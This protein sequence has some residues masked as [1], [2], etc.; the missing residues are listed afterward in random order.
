MQWQTPHPPSDLMYSFQTLVIELPSRVLERK[1]LEAERRLE[2]GSGGIELRKN[3]GAPVE[4]PSSIKDSK[5]VGVDVA[6]AE[7]LYA[8]WNEEDGEKKAICE[9]LTESNSSS[10]IVHRAN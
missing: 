2:I 7:E 10:E 6:W 3:K 4:R 8:L 9:G 1:G 5:L